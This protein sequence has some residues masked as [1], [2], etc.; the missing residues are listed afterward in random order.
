MPMS[1]PLLMSVL[2]SDLGTPGVAIKPPDNSRTT[3]EKAYRGVGRAP[4]FLTHWV[5]PKRRVNPVP[6]PVPGRARLCTAIGAGCVF[7]DA[8]E[9]EL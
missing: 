5:D 1:A 7:K 9:I 2:N 6:D 3:Q 8:T 4:F